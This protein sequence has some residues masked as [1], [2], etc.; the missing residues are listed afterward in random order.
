MLTGQVALFCPGATAVA[1]VMVIG[2]RAFVVGML[3]IIYAIQYRRANTHPWLTGLAG[4]LSAVFGLPVVMYAFP[5]AVVSLAWL[6]G[7]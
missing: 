6:I 3:E 7:R 2:Y 1:L 4:L 5:D